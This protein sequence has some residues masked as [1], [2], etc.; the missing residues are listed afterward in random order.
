MPIQSFQIDENDLEKV[1]NISDLE[2]RSV[3]QI[4]RISLQ[5][6]IKNFEEELEFKKEGRENDNS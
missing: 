3:S 2:N 5:K 6:F 1:K 4:I